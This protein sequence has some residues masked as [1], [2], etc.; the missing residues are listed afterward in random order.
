VVAVG[1]DSKRKQ[2]AVA[3]VRAAIPTFII[4]TDRSEQS[5]IVVEELVRKKRKISTAIG[6][7]I[8]ICHSIE[9][10]EEGELFLTLII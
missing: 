9:Q 5:T 10:E 6:V 1:A 4:L 8:C 7:V 2:K 3:L